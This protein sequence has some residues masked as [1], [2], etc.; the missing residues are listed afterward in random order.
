M[1]IDGEASPKNLSEPTSDHPTSHDGSADIPCRPRADIKEQTIRTESI[2]PRGEGTSMHS[3]SFG[4]RLNSSIWPANSGSVTS[5]WFSRTGKIGIAP[6]AG[7]FPRILMRRC[8][9]GYGEKPNIPGAE[10]RRPCGR[11]SPAPSGP[12]PAWFK[13]QLIEQ[14]DRKWLR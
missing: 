7:P 8:G 10:D 3:K 12:V 14:R 9:F 2:S 13:A 4:L 6:T 5:K 1:P 11:A